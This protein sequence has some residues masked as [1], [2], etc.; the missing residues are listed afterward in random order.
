MEDIVDLPGR[1][2]MKLVGH[3]GYLGGYLERS[4][5]PW[6]ELGCDIAWKLEVLSF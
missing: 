1:G 4:I 3:M 2:E 6:G 5:P